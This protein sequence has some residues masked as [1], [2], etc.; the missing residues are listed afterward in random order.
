MSCTRRAGSRNVA[1]SAW[2]ACALALTAVSLRV[3]QRDA[4][5]FRAVGQRV[6]Y[7]TFKNMAR[8]LRPPP[9]VAPHQHHRQHH[10]RLFPSAA[11]VCRTLEA[12]TGAKHEVRSAGTLTGPLSSLHAHTRP[13]T[14]PFCVEWIVAICIFMRLTP[15][16]EPWRLRGSLLPTERERGTQS[17]SPSPNCQPA[18]PRRGRA[19]SE[20]LSRHAVTLPHAQKARPASLVAPQRNETVKVLNRQ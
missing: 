6:D 4:A 7:D 10:V 3:Q 19:A 5:K 13:E 12:T 20:S 11:G 9:R 8:L 14:A 17:H 18:C 1:S 2:M 15:Q 16:A